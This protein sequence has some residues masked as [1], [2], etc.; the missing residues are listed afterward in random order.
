MEHQIALAPDLEI[1]HEELADAW[2]F[3]PS[4]IVP[5]SEGRQP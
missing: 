1:S 5:Y 4:T 3:P 2:N